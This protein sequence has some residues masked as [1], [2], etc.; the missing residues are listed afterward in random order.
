M[1][2]GNYLLFKYLYIE[3]S[4]L[5]LKTNT[6]DYHPFCMSLALQR[7]VRPHRIFFL[8]S[9]TCSDSLTTEASSP[10]SPCLACKQFALHDTPKMR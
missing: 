1:C 8:S 10:N 6:A 9:D 4:T 3:T 2:V 5:F 7:I